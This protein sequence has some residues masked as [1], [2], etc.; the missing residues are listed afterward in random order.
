M[1]CSFKIEAE[2]TCMN[3]TLEAKVRLVGKEVIPY[4]AGQTEAWMY[5]D[6]A[7]SKSRYNLSYDQAAG[8][9]LA[10]VPN[11]CG[12]VELTVYGRVGERSAV[13]SVQVDCGTCGAAAAEQG[14]LSI[15]GRVYNDSNGDSVKGADEAG[16]EGWDVLLTRPDG[17][18]TVVK[19]DRKG[20]YIFTGLSSGFYEM[21]SIAQKNWTAT[22]PDA[23]GQN[24][25]LIDVHESEI[26]FGFRT[27]KAEKQPLNIVEEFNKTF[28]G[29]NFDK[30]NS[31]QLVSDG[32]YILAGQTQ[33]FGSGNLDAWS[34]KT[35]AQGNEVWNRTFVGLDID[36]ATRREAEVYS[37]Q[38][39]SDGGYILVGYSTFDGINAWLIKINAEGNEVWNKTFG[40]AYYDT[41]NSVQ[42]TSDGGYILAGQTQSFG[43][44]LANAWLI[45]TDA[46]GNEVW[47]KT[48][49]GESYNDEANSV[50]VTSDG[51]YILAGTTGTRFLDAWLIKTDS[52]GNE[53]WSKTLGGE[54]LEEGS[55]VLSTS[56]GGYILAGWTYSFGAGSWDAW[57][58]K[59]NVD[60]NI[61]SLPGQ[62]N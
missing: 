5:L 30:A 21:E 23:S 31:V 62:V 15:S 57:L 48:F 26:D 38:P 10:E 60:G 55:S 43:S 20:H 44:G 2:T 39:T 12:P 46:E 47:N 34:I 32:G 13:E 17:V 24:V 35:D 45:K 14:A 1:S 22:A 7:G 25:E 18:S 37:V 40:G 29:S 61:V 56:N 28:G 36:G 49:G 51:G 54:N 27:E 9:Y 4:L 42:V 11:I 3:R 8:A 19:T 58:I 52:Q 6:Q 16:L 41:A 59:V 33:S 50:Q 53:V